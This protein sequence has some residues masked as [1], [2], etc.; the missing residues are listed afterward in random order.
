MAD[1]V[2]PD[3]SGPATYTQLADE[4]G[5]L[6]LLPTAAVRALQAKGITRLE[7]VVII[8]QP[9][10]SQAALT[11]ADAVRLAA[12]DMPHM[13]EKGIQSAV[14]RAIEKR[15]IL[16][17]LHDDKYRLD[18]TSFDAWRLRQRDKHLDAED[19]DE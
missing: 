17:I 8:P 7:L 3:G 10:S 12:A 9:T 1:I 15:D 6:L 14:R 13:S 18:A 4:A 2:L 16:T 11:L 5:R 19:A